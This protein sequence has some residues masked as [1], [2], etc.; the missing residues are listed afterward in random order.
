MLDWFRREI[1][2]EGRLPLL[3][4]LVGFVMAFAFIRLSVRMIRA[5]VRW[6]PGNVT[7]GGVHVHHVVFGVVAM[8][9]AGGGLIAFYEDGNRA[10][11]V[12]FAAL[13]GI[14]AALTL[15]EFALIF[16]LNDV[17][18]EKEGRIS[19]DAVFVAIAVTGMLLVGLRPLD[20]GDP[21]E[22]EDTGDLVGRAALVVSVIVDLI[23]ATIVLAK[24]KIWTG[25][26]GLFFAP[27][28][29]VGAIRL[30]RPAAPWARTRYAPGSRKMTRALT[31]ERRIRRPVIRVKIV[32]QDLVAG[33]PTLE[34]VR[35]SVE[36]SKTEAEEVLDRQVHPATPP[37]SISPAGASSGT[38]D[39][40]PRSGTPT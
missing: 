17:Y 2:D 11:G 34:T 13:F 27:L 22:F 15:D 33:A 36:N 10:A 16:Y 26:V 30:S 4:F 6:W 1:V 5:N 38:I 18:W 23:L 7:P 28:L 21:A 9:I 37:S 25:L 20:L 40:L 19:V 14:G 29:W 35:G 39:G 12:V 24:G 31:R 8:V 3:C 32:V